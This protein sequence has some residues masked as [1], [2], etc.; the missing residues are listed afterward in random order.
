[1]K[2]FLCSVLAVLLLLGIGSAAE[3][4][5]GLYAPE[6]KSSQTAERG[7]R[8]SSS[9]P[10]GKSGLIPLPNAQGAPKVTLLE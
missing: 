6:E 7:G 5:P 4:D 2:R 3:P 1:M 8:E 9:V 10:G